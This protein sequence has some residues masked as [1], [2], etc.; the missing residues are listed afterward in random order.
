MAGKMEQ[1]LIAIDGD[2]NPNL[3]TTLGLPREKISQIVPIPRTVVNRTKDENGKNKTVLTKKP[4]EIIDEFGI[5]TPDGIKL[6][7]MAAIDH[8]GAG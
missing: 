5:D 3:A 1:N 6:L 8:A 4:D 7:L 2:S